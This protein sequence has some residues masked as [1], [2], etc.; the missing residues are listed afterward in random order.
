MP[1]AVLVAIL[2]AVSA[3]LAAQT[4]GLTG[5]VAE[6]AAADIRAKVLRH[7]ASARRLINA[8]RSR[9]GLGPVRVD[10]TLAN[11]A[12]E[13]ALDLARSGLTGHSGSDGS[14]PADR[15][16]R[17]GYVFD[18]IGENASAGRTDLDDVI[19]AW[20]DSPGHRRN[21][22]LHPASDFGLAH[23]VAPGTRYG[24]YWVLLMGE[25]RSPAAPPGSGGRNLGNGFVGGFT[26][27]RS[28]E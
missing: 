18:N 6:A 20:I 3:T 26:G 11:T 19:R 17:N 10:P 15:A 7:D 24:H 22:T 8:Y 14:N 13:H 5:P 9:R 25:Q 27:R 1:R 16:L 28:G 12:A 4:G 2:L 21:L 23:V